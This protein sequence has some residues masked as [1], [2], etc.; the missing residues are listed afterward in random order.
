[1]IAALAKGAYDD[2]SALGELGKHIYNVSVLD[3]SS[4][5][6]KASKAVLDGIS[7]GVKWAVNNPDKFLSSV[8]ENQKQFFISK[9]EE[10]HQALARG[11]LVAAGYAEGEIFYRISE[12]ASVIALPATAPKAVVGAVK[13]AKSAGSAVKNAWRRRPAAG[14][15]NFMANTDQFFLNARN[16]VDIDPNGYFD[17]VAHGSANKIQINTPNGPKIVDHRTAAQ[18]IKR[19]PGY[20]GQSIRLLSCS[21]GQ[22]NS[23][24]AQNL[25]NKLNVTVEAP[26]DILWAYPNGKMVIAPKAPNGGPDLSRQGNFKK[27]TPGGNVGE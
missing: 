26:T 5:K 2:V 17:V 22:C 21:T 9:F 20:N 27:F 6:Y 4:S 23:G 7:E 25:A 16:R 12:I 10:Y 3:K 1:M 13:L 14:A 18:L 19:Q 8:G 11:D 24:F 15:V